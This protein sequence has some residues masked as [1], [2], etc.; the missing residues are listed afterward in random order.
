M[1]TL[2]S[3]RMFAAIA[4]NGSLSAVAR[5]WGVA[6]STISYGLHALEDRLGAQLVFRTTRRLS[7]TDEGQRFLIESRRILADVD[8]VMTGLSDREGIKGN[9][10]ITCTNDLGRQRIAPLVDLFMR[11]HP[12]VTVE[13]FLHDRVIDLID[14]GFDLAI[15]TGPLQAS[16]LKARLLLRGTKS[17]C[18]SP[19][20]WARH[21]KPTHPDDLARHNCLMLSEPGERH[22]LWRFRRG[23]EE[24]RVRVSGD[25]Q[26]NDGEALRQWAI[27]GAGVVQKS[28][29]DIAGDI[30]NGLLETALEDFTTAATNLYAVAPSRQHSS[31]RA[32]A[33]VDFLLER[34][35]QADRS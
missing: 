10:R 29:F 34:M 32:T 21:G 2:K 4:E 15:R 3:M 13:L 25:R 6:P 14:G 17:I 31:T 11:E 35:S 23:E 20:Y 1:D 8:E 30:R 28:S 26:V 33:F 5:D 24:I 19:G 16:E 27:A 12:N 22:A 9:I 7:L 18:A